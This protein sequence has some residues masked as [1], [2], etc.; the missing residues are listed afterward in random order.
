MKVNCTVYTVI[1]ISDRVYFL[2]SEGDTVN[3]TDIEMLTYF[4]TCNSERPSCFFMYSL[5]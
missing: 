3:I 1:V 4:N 5:N 2:S